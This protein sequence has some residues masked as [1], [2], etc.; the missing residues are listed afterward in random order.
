[1]AVPLI[2]PLVAVITEVPGF[3]AVNTPVESIVP[4]VVL[5]PVHVTVA[6]IGWPYWSLDEAVND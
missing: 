3:I 2:A 4:T 6:V 1:M 5:L